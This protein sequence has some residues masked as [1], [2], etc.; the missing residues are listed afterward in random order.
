M[1]K[2][3]PENQTFH[4]H[5]GWVLT[6]IGEIGNTVT[7]NTPPTSQ[8]ENYEKFF[9]FEKPLELQRGF[10]AQTLRLLSLKSLTS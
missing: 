10:F 3:V 7:R 4:L 2:T 8:T 1:D 5:K 6:T 9:P